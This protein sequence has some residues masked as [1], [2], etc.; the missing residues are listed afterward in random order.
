MEQVHGIVNFKLSFI[1]TITE[2]DGGVA[3]KH[4]PRECLGNMIELCAASLYPDPKVSLGFAMCLSND[5]EHIPDQDLIESC[6]LEHRVDFGKLNH[7]VSRDDGFGIGLLRKSME[8]SAQAGVT[9]SCTVRLNEEVRCVLDSGE[10]KDC[11]KGHEVDDL[12]QDI[13]ALYQD[14]TAWL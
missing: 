14:A 6:A 3:C 9:T 8:R 5:Y 1:G 12:V 11:E 7:C 13:K 10:W 2:G 4:G